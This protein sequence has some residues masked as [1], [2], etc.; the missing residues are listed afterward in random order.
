MEIPVVVVVA[1]VVVVVAVSVAVVGAP[2][3]GAQ[4]GAAWIIRQGMVYPD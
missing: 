3:G 2:L 4:Q 1:V